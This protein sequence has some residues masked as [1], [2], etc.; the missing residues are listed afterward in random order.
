MAAGVKYG[1]M[2][3]LFVFCHCFATHHL[4]CIIIRILFISL[5]YDLLVVY[6]GGYGAGSVRREEKERRKRR[7]IFRGHDYY[8]IPKYVCVEIATIDSSIFYIKCRARRVECWIA[9]TR[10]HALM[11]RHTHRNQ[12][13][14]IDESGAS[15]PATCRA[16]HKLYFCKPVVF[17]SDLLLTIAQSSLLY[18]RPSCTPIST[19]CHHNSVLL[20]TPRVPIPTQPAPQNPTEDKLASPSRPSFADT[21]RRSDRGTTYHYNAL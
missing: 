13:R 19:S 9:N 18:R 1:K 3:I 15:T 10:R 2:R 8:M 6:H 4:V 7:R 21:P 11:S 5:S 16:G 12:R 17:N 14:A 20:V